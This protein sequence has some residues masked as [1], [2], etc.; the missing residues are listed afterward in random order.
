MSMQ[1]QLRKGADQSASAARETLRKGEAKAQQTME[2]VQE[3]LQNAGDGARQMGLKLVEIA[4]ANAEAFYS[5]AEDVLNE[6]DP[7]KLASVWS[8]HTQNQMEL[9]G[10]QGQEL[11]S[12]GQKL[13]TTGVNTMS[14][15]M[16]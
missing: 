8:K 16:R 15:R 11:A 1:E 7:T 5:F 9:L 6:R 3:G 2:A 14:D 4:R 10:R 12:L 13:A